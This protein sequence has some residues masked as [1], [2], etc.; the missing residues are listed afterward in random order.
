MTPRPSMKRGPQSRN[1]VSTK[2]GEDQSIVKHFD[3]LKD[4]LRGFRPRAVLAMINQF[5]LEGA[6]EAFDAGVVP[7]I[8]TAGHAPRDARGGELLLVCGRG[9]L[10]ASIGMME[11][12]GLRRAAVEGHL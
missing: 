12:S 6:E 3:V 4:L 2:L 8:P 1:Q 11:E 7:A 10:T 5:S 9:I